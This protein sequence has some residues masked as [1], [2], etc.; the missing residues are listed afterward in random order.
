M[1]SLHN[2][3]RSGRDLHLAG[4]TCQVTWWD[5]LI[6]GQQESGSTDDPTLGRARP[7]LRFSRT[8]SIPETTYVGTNFMLLKDGNHLTWVQL[9]D[10]GLQ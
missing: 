10:E 5:L 3:R 6:A 9:A 2:P 8:P 4:C 7:W 1:L